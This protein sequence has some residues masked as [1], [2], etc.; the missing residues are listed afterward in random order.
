MLKKKCMYK[1]TSITSKIVVAQVKYHYVT[2]N[3][4]E[5]GQWKTS[6]ARKENL[7]LVG[8]QCTAQSRIR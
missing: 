8:V 1:S 2:A 4:T 3:K 5:E 6:L 7:S